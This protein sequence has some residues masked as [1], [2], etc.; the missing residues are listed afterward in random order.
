MPG[1]PAEAAAEF[2]DAAKSTPARRALELQQR[3]GAQLL[4]G[5]HLEEGLEIFANVLRAAGFTLPKGP[6]RALLSLVFGVL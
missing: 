1:R 4:M 3:A 2:L 5:G 6:K